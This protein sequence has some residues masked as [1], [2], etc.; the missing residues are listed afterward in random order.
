MDEKFR[1]SL[2]R[3]ETPF[4]FIDRPVS[5]TIFAIIVVSLL[6]HAI[7]VLREHRARKAR[8]AAGAAPPGPGDSSGS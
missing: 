3:V 2:A 4:D 7:A 1:A 5:G 6:A 8:V